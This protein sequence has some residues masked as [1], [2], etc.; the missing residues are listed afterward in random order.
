[1]GDIVDLEEYRK[2]RGNQT[3]EMRDPQTGRP[4]TRQGKRTT[5]KSPRTGDSPQPATDDPPTE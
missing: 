4:G 5:E 3:A 2:R 1:M